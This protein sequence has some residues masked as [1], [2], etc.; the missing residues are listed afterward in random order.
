MRPLESDA[1]VAD[2]Q[3]VEIV[4]QGRLEGGDEAG[5]SKTR[6]ESASII[7]RVIDLVALA[8]L[9]GDMRAILGEVAP[10][11]VDDLA[12]KML[13][14]EPVADQL[15]GAVG[16]AGVLD[17]HVVDQGANAFEAAQDDGGLVL[18]DHAQAYRGRSMSR[19]QT[20]SSP[21]AA[22]S[23]ATAL[24]LSFSSGVG[25]MDSGGARRCLGEDRTTRQRE[26]FFEN[27]AVQAARRQM[28]NSV[29]L[30]AT[31]AD[32]SRHGVEIAPTS[33][34]FRTD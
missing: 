2:L 16:G 9:L 27:C 20:V 5:P 3:V 15:L 23:T 7:K 12:R 33:I 25:S 31:P 4:D 22:A 26:C 30:M 24:R 11:L 6:R 17:Q 1:A 21:V 19:T 10:G 34:C 14:T 13:L 8:Q 29:I 18:D 32:R 28:S